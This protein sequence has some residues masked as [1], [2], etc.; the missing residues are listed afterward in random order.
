MDR[1]PAMPVLLIAGFTALYFASQVGRERL[2]ADED[3]ALTWLERRLMR[4]SFP[5]R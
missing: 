5:T 4:D 1:T 3:R 2:A